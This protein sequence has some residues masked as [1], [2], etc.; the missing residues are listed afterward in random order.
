MRPVCMLDSLLFEKVPYYLVARLL[1]QHRLSAR[2]I[3]TG[4]QAVLTRGKKKRCMYDDVGR[5]SPP[6]SYIATRR[7]VCNNRVN[8]FGTSCLLSDYNSLSYIESLLILMF[9]LPPFFFSA[10]C[11]ETQTIKYDQQKTKRRT[12]KY[13]QQKLLNNHVTKNK[14]R[15][16]KS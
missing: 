6:S 1:C 2:V 11:K 15:G 8:T 3:F 14:K 16:A 12:T 7:L 13:D 4:R 9:N 10:W 5:S